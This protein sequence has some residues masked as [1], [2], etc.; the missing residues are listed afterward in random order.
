MP[1]PAEQPPEGVGMDHVLEGAID[2]FHAALRD[3]LLYP[4]A[5]PGGRANQDLRVI[6]ARKG[7]VRAALHEADGGPVKRTTADVV[8]ELEQV[9]VLVC[10]ECRTLLYAKSPWFDDGCKCGSRGVVIPMV[11][12]TPLPPPPQEPG[13]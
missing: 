13:K 4:S 10:W 8:G 9:A 6:L 1:E 5:S 12:R 3:W 7:I 11:L 2:E